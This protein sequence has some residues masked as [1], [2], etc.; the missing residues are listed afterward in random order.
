MKIT[1]TYGEAERRLAALHELERMTNNV[2][3]IAGLRITQNIHALEQ[4]TAPYH[5]MRDT[6]IKKY[7]KGGS[8]VSKEQDPAAF[9]A[10][11]QEIADIASDEMEVEIR[12]FPL[13]LVA[14]RE[15]PMNTLFAME[16]MIDES[17]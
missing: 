3:A 14:D 15:F 7:A 10:C 6:I 12:T 11:T 9:R 2:P 5:T 17:Q 16:F 13:K 4:A 1:M 8:S